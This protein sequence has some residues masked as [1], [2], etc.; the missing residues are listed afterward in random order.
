MGRICRMCCPETKR[1]VGF[2]VLTE[3]FQ[4]SVSGTLSSLFSELVFDR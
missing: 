4:L 3:R 1:A 2:R